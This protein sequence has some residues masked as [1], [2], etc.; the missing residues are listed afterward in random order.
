MFSQLV[1]S[2]CFV[3]KTLAAFEVGSNHL[4]LNIPVFLCFCY[5][6]KSILA[7]SFKGNFT[8]LF[9]QHRIQIRPKMMIQFVGF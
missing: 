4:L 2:E 6:D 5:F 3:F 9:H 1:Y 7:K 8:S